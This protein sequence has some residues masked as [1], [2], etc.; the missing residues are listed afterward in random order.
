MKTAVLVLAMA[1]LPL[2]AQVDFRQSADHI[3][4]SID[5]KPFGA[6]YFGEDAPKPY[7]S[8]LRSAS[9][10][11]VTRRFP[12]E[13]VEGET[14]D[15]PHHRGLWFTHGDVNQIDFWANEPGGKGRKGKVKLEKIHSVNGG[16]KDG[17]IRAS[18]LW[19]DDAGEPLV[20]ELRTMTFYSDPSLRMLDFDATL[21]AV[22][23]AVFGDTKEGFF[24]IR[25]R[26][27]MRERGG[28]GRMIN[29]EGKSGMR[30]VWGKASPWVDYCGTLEGEKLGVAIFDHPQSFR[31]P[32]YWHA[33]DYG[34]FAANAFG[35]HDFY[36]DKT[37]D[38]S[39]ALEPGQSI[40]FL[41]RVL[42]HPGDTESAG[43]A[44]RFAEFAKKKF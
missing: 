43:I 5:G 15:H 42:I 38:G 6:L 41:Y 19:V 10:I 25:L 26:D 29:A 2:L 20:R 21:T 1:T 34:L 16:K 32:T 9:G 24:A 30:E 18:F 11:I 12:M 31:H 14:R 37:K 36:N 27:E 28:T 17:S 8:P 7:L 44:A 23:R 40:R 35:L 3:D 13:K 4:I 33:R 22:K 39:H